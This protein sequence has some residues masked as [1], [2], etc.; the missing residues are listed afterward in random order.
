MNYLT[1]HW[2]KLIASFLLGSATLG[3]AT[4]G[5]S[6]FPYQITSSIKG[7]VTK[8]DPTNLPT[9]YLVAGSQ[10]VII[11]DQEK[12]ESRAGY[13]IFGAASTTATAVTSDFSWKHS[14]ATSTAP[15]EILL[16][17]KD[18]LIQ[19]YAT[20][21]FEDLWSG[22]STTSPVR[23]ATVWD[24]S[25][26]MDTLLSV[27]ASSTLMKW[28]GGQAT[29]AST[30]STT[31]GINEEIGKSRFFIS[32]THR[33]R[34]K[35]S[36]GVWREFS[37]T[38]IG[39][40][41]S[42][43]TGVTP[44]PTSF[45]FGTNA[46]I[47]Q[48][49]EFHAN[50]P[51][52][53]FLSDTISVL[54]NQVW[55]GSENSRFVFVSKDTSYT[56]FTFS[57]PRTTGQGAKLTL[58]STTV[59]FMAPDDNKMLV[60]S[61]D[62]RVYQVSFEISSSDTGTVE[63]PRI[64]PLLVSSGQ[65]AQ[66]QELIAKIKQAV[67]WISNNNELVELGQVENLPSP[68]A[69]AISDPIK[70]DFSD[71]TF[72]NGEIEFW[73][74]SIFITDPVDGKMFIFD[75][76]KRFWQPPQVLGMRRVSVFGNQLYG[77]SNSVPETYTLFMGLN[78]NGNPISFK[79]HFAYRNGNRRDILKNFDKFFTE[80]YLAG[81]TTVTVE[82]LYEWQGAKQITEYDLVGSNTAFLFT[83]NNSAALGVNPLGTNPLGGQLQVAEQSPKYR[84]FKPIVP[85][86]F[87][88]YAPHFE[89]DSDDGAFQIVAFG[90]NLRQSGN[91]ASKLNQ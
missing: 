84:R 73:E 52:A 87:F 23:F 27:N 60:F 41:V 28:S 64:K 59:G 80:L 4:L 8:T 7:Y 30:T 12:V 39:G 56:D 14:G 16:R 66:S 17:T 43:F 54:N 13:E 86:D 26:Q 53:G 91:I 69:I 45:T 76:S 71:A 22:V 18:N 70:P 63:L 58:D 19:Y 65:G 46:S 50:T 49:I 5:A 55:I 78:D 48:A 51:Q 37:H 35:D 29:V 68:Q 36:G 38:G 10:N 9:D 90:E 62:D 61:G 79:A 42:T 32:G 25:E 34:I 81:N 1:V 40:G 47:V 82:L 33:F 11:N 74:N 6:E 67:V 44:D 20:S 88:E 85:A 57:S 83:P 24:S 89:S 72:T 2:K 3:A 15:S 21:T 31:V 77:H 75:M